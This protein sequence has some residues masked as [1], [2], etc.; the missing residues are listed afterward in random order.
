MLRKFSILYGKQRR[1]KSVCVIMPV[2]NRSI[3]GITEKNSKPERNR[4]DIRNR[5]MLQYIEM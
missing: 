5:G 4:Y 2:M 3:P 1:K